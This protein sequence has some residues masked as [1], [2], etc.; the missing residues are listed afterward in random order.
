MQRRDQLPGVPFQQRGFGGP[1]GGMNAQQSLMLS[2]MYPGSSQ[3]FRMQQAQNLGLMG[4]PIQPG[5][6]Q[7]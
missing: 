4:G 2:R 6:F 1:G 5:Q 7:R 3:A